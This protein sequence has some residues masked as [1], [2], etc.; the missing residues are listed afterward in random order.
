MGGPARGSVV[1]HL[2]GAL[3]G[4][5]WGA[6]GVIAVAGVSA[7]SAHQS[8]RK[9]SAASAAGAGQ[10]ARGR[11]EGA[12]RGNARPLARLGETRPLR[13]PAERAC[14]VVAAPSSSDTR[15]APSGGAAP[16]DACERQRRAVV[17]CLAPFPPT[18]SAR[19][20]PKSARRTMEPRSDAPLAP[21]CRWPPC[22]RAARSASGVARWPGPGAA[23]PRACAVARRRGDDGAGAI[24]AVGH[25]FQKL[26]HR[27]GLGA[28]GGTSASGV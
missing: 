19:R 23:G 17:S 6:I 28:S 1:C 22:A 4:V 11:H 2:G 24:E 18:E 20:P 7:S 5:L 21:L 8:A 26:G 16:G 3:R 9:S 27:L 15:G 25:F 10:I 13:R 14:S 12:A